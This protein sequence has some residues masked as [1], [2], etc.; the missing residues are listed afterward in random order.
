MAWK[1]V[2]AQLVTVVIAATPTRKRNDLG[3][4]FKHVTDATETDIPSSRCFWFELESEWMVG[5]LTPG[6][7][8]RKRAVVRFF[9]AY[10]SEAKRAELFEDASDDHTVVTSKLLDASLWDRPTSTI[11]GVVLGG[12][13]LARASYDDV[14]GALLMSMPLEIEFYHAVS[15]GGL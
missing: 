7:P 13:Q 3:A 9:M 2:Q 15:G 8:T 10:L 14:D 11:M 12:D 5:P 1:D 4:T 6:L